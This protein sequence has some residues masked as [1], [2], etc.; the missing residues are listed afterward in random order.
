M[1]LL[2]IDFSA[3]YFTI[4]LESAGQLFTYNSISRLNDKIVRF[5]VALTLG[6]GGA[7]WRT[8]DIF[9]TAI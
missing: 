7:Q 6:E 9:A 1:S 8:F 3:H 5:A 2:L 4:C